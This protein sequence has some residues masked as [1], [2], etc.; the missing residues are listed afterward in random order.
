MNRE[1]WV[2]LINSK[3]TP[4]LFLWEYCKHR[5]KKDKK[6]FESLCE[7]IAITNIDITKLVSYA[8]SYICTEFKLIELKDKNGYLLKVY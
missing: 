1:D 2:D 6:M 3:P 5:G 8:Y 7:I 4:I